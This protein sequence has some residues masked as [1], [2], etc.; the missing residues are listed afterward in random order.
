MRQLAQL[1]VL[2]A[3]NFDAEEITKLE[4]HLV[5]RRV[6][7]ALADAVHR[8]G[9]DFGSRAEA[10]HRVPGADAKVVMKVDDKGRVRRRR[11]DRRYV[12]AHRKR[13][14]AANCVRGRWT[15]TAGLQ[16][17]AVDLGDVTD[18]RTRTVFAAEL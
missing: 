7:G 11:F 18:V 12:L 13:R 5:H 16:P 14:V 4:Q 3:A 8:G 1:F 9:E 10:D 17:F 15:G 6:A 2:E